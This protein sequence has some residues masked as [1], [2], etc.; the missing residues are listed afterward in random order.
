MRKIFVVLGLV[1]VAALGIGCTQ[2]AISTGP[3]GVSG[4]NRDLKALFFTISATTPKSVGGPFTLFDHPSLEATLVAVDETGAQ[5]QPKIEKFPY[6][7]EWY[8]GDSTDALVC[9]FSNFGLKSATAQCNEPGFH[10]FCVKTVI[11]G[12]PISGCNKFKFQ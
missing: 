1:G 12:T 6:P 8:F 9:E 5:S 2:D 10:E 4:L 3:T 7:L 11:D